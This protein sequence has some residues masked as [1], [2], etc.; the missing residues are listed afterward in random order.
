MATPQQVID[1]IQADIGALTGMRGAPHEAPEAINAY[2]FCVAYVE[3]GRSWS[4]I[5]GAQIILCNI[6][7]DLHVARKDMPRDIARAMP[8][9]ATI[10][11]ALHKPMATNTGDRFD[12]T[13]DAMGEISF[14]FGALDYGTNE[15]IGFSFLIQDVKIQTNIT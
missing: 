9:L 13:V 1:A 11:N 3:S 4:D 5:P 10:L 2:P 7:L 14:T 8:W 12:S 6:R 15:T